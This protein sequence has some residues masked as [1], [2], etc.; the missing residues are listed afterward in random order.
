MR[1]TT[2]AMMCL[3]MVIWKNNR[4]VM[5]LKS[6]LHDI[7]IS[8]MALVTNKV[9]IITYK[10]KGDVTSDKNLKHVSL[11]IEEI[12][13]HHHSIASFQLRARLA[14]NFIAWCTESGDNWHKCHIC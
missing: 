8:N 13:P 1:H 3:H 5:A 7:S 11:K 12:H 6:M 10:E 9:K 2:L 14:V 4:K